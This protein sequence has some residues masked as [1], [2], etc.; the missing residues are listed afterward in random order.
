MAQVDYKQIKNFPD[1]ATKDQVALLYDLVLRLIANNLRAGIP[2][3]DP[4]LLSL[5]QAALET[6]STQQDNSKQPII[7]N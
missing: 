4:I 3:Q 7:T 5:T 2:I 1:L 6:I